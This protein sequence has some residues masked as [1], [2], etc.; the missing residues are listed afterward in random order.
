MLK[1]L[2]LWGALVGLLAVPVLGQAIPKDTL[3]IGADTGIIVDLD[4]ARAYEVFTNTVIEQLYDNLVDFEGTFEVIKP[5][6]AESWEASADGMTWTF[7]LRQGVKFH[8]GNEVNADAVVFSFTRALALNFAPIWMLDQYVPSADNVKKIDE[9]TVAITT[10]VALSEGLMGAIMGVQGICAIIDPSVVEAHK[11]AEDPWAYKWLQFHDAGSGP[12]GLVEWSPNDRVVLEGFDAYWDGAPKTK[13]VIVI[14]IPERAQQRLA[15]ENGTVDIAWDLLPEA[16]D[17]LR[18]RDGFTLYESPGWSITYLCMNVG[19][20]PFDNP[21]VRKA[22]KYA[23]DYDAIVNGIMKGAAIIGETF[24]PVG[25]PGHLEA[26]PYHKDVEKAKQLLADAGY[27]DGFTTQII[28]QPTSPRKDIATQVQQDLAEVGIKAD[29]VQLISAQMYELY[30]GQE[31]YLLV[32][33]WGV[34]YGHGDSLVKPFAHCC[35]TGDDAPVRQL[36]W[37][38][39]YSN[40]DLTALVDKTETELDEAKKLEMYE[41]IQQVILDDGP[42]AIMFYPLNQ[43]A[44]LDTVKGF[45]MM[46]STSYIELCGVYKE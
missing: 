2:L 4:P 26:T 39:M 5:A 25:I 24:I 13:N 37:R 16:M 42:F 33:G 20:E 36:A 45:V 38:N 34:D 15:L 35:S 21:L 43:I 22:I 19:K 11:T 3:V 6:L 29:L 41:Q 46:N 1:R 23:I 44:S 27:P 31:H 10:K 14:D 30:R 8:S 17:E 40:C 9:Y 18:D 32:A 12:Y 7:H 28:C